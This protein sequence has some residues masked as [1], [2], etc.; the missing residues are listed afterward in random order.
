MKLFFKQ[1]SKVNATAKSRLF[2]DT[3]QRVAGLLQTLPQR[4]DELP[5]RNAPAKRR[6]PG[7]HAG[8]IRGLMATF[9]ASL[10]TLSRR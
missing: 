8:E 5:R 3:L 2:G 1:P 7:K 10:S 6:F 4:P 9:S